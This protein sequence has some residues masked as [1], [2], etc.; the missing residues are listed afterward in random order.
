MLVARNVLGIPATSVPA[1]AI[2]SRGKA[3]NNTRFNLTPSNFELFVMAAANAEA[4]LARYTGFDKGTRKWPQ[5]R[6]TGASPTMMRSRK[7]DGEGR[8]RTQIPIQ[9]GHSFTG[10][11][12][13]RCNKVPDNKRIISAP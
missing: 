3:I 8:P 2:F 4:L 10:P 6:A 13:G 1:E 9:A 11:R 12:V 7:V 5:R